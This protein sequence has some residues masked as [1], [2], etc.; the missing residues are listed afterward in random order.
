MRGDRLARHSAQLTTILEE[1]C[2]RLA[3]LNSFT[4]ERLLTVGNIA[5]STTD[6]RQLTLR[7][8]NSFSAGITQRVLARLEKAPWDLVDGDIEQNVVALEAGECPA[9]CV[10]RCVF[11]LRRKRLPIHRVV[12]ALRLLLQLGWSS[13]VAEQAHATV[14]MIRRWHQ[15]YSLLLLVIRSMLLQMWKQVPKESRSLHDKIRDHVERLVARLPQRVSA[16][17][18]HLQTVHAAHSLA[19]GGD[20]VTF[21]D[22]RGLMELAADS[23]NQL[24]AED[25]HVEYLRSRERFHFM[26]DHIEVGESGGLSLSGC[27]RSHFLNPTSVSLAAP[28]LPR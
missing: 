16:F 11:Q 12:K 15:E 26:Q 14:A 28:V 24:S 2:A 7:C 17:G 3:R 10:S 21:E 6:L 25:R 18:M 4:W 22:G 27:L 19:T 8:V 5:E 23:W 13:M 1:E 9:E 20:E